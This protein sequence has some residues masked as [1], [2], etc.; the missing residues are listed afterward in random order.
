[1]AVFPGFLFFTSRQIDNSDVSSD[2][3]P[4]FAGDFATRSLPGTTLQATAGDVHNQP[5]TVTGALAGLGG[6]GFELPNHGTYWFER[7]HV[8]PPQKAYPFILS[9]QHLFVEVYNAFRL[10][11]KSVASI[12][13]TGPAGV[14]IVTPYVLPI[15][16]AP[17]S[18]RTYDLL[19][20]AAGAP[21]AD[22]FI[23]WDFTGLAEPILHLTGLRLLPFTVSPDWDAGIDDV[24]GYVT[25]VMVAYDDTE[26]RIML[27]M[28]PNRSLSYKASGLEPRESGLLAS[29]LWSWQ[30]RS[31]GVPLWMDGAPLQADVVA[32]SV[33]LL[34]DTT[35]MALGVGDTVIVISD[36]FNWFAS[37]VLE[38]TP[39]T[40]KLE[41]QLDRDFFVN[42]TQVI[43][44]ILGR[45][46][47]AVGME[48]PT[49]ASTVIPI[50]FDLQVVSV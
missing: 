10:L 31:Y 49:N 43:P 37:P 15:S 36:A 25:D 20:D 12:I 6:A 18:S 41:T 46:A 50:K 30:A 24:V 42:R 8:M 29:L 5:V 23:Q 33:D 39:G 28:V 14:T 3:Q 16:F 1:M 22:N 47:E 19:I 13:E 38:L 4:A 21:R 48:R 7:I 2:L 26:Q 11:T 9:P 44:V 32:G 40:I 27:R 17:L 35:N 34:V 45:I